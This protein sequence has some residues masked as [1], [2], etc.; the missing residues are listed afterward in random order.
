MFANLLTFPYRFAV[1]AR[2]WLYKQE[3]MKSKRLPCPVVSVGNLSVGG[4][5][6]TPMTMWVAQYV[7]ARGKKVAILSRGYRRHSRETFL[8]V[9]NGKEILVSQNE[10]GDEPFLMATCCPGVIVAVGANRYELGRWVL[11]RLAIDCFVLD[12][13]FQH[14]GLARDLNLLLIDISDSVGM[15]SLLPV[16]R[17]REPLSEA[18]RATSIIFTRVEDLEEMEP[19]RQRLERAVGKAV[20]PIATRFEAERLTSRNGD[21]VHD[22]SLLK[23]KRV[24]IFSGVANASSFRRLVEGLAAQVVADLRYSDHMTYTEETLRQIHEQADKVQAQVLLTTEK[25]LVK[26]Q[27]LWPYSDP[28]WALSV[29][30]KFLE[31]QDR[32]EA[33]LQTI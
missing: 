28:V 31:V 8:L 2:L 13:G 29:G 24:L 17:L 1:S 14:V 12:D 26:V 27:P 16:G 32:L 3:W 5:G 11:D 10:A 30:I 22:P 19:M 6:K 4:T 7:A 23:G 18:Q 20:S 33:Q 15:Q 21:V 9:S 25:D